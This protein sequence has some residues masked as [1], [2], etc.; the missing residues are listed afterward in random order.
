MQC[1]T[2]AENTAIGSGSLDALSTGDN[3]TALGRMSGTQLTTGGDNTLIG[4]YAGQAITTQ[5]ANTI[6][7]KSAGNAN[8]ASDNT[9]IG[10]RCAESA[11]TGTNNVCIGKE[12]SLS[13]AHGNNQFVMGNS[14]TDNL[15][16]NDTSISSLS[17]QRDKTEIVDLPI[18]LDFINAVRPV[19]FKW[20]TRDGNIKDGRIDAGFIAQELQ[21][22][23]NSKSVDY[24]NLVQDDNPDKLE[25]A[26][27]RLFP[28]M[29]KAIQELSAKVK[30]L[31]SR[32]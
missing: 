3:N 13:V 23:Q 24:L 10:H 9:Y 8:V 6:V 12:S 29:V 21:A 31:E 1:G 15:R 22:L 17:D 7:G 16:C 28:L 26:P 14:N 18:G 30:E 11:T 20:A 19:Q 5:G 25:A 4:Y 27:N 2:G 32:Q